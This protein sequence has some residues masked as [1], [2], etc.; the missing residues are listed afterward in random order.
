MLLV[1]STAAV[2]ATKATRAASLYAILLLFCMGNIFILKTYSLLVCCY[3]KTYLIVRYFIGNNLIF[4]YKLL[5]R[6]Y[7]FRG[8]N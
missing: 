8:A 4:P 6:R 2:A 3:L 5:K 1:M 7:S